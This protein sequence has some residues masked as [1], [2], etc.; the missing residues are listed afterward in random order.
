MNT[1][2]TFIL[3]FCLLTSII[4]SCNFSENAEKRVEQGVKD[5]TNKLIDDAKSAKDNFNTTL[6]T[7]KNSHDYDG[8]TNELNSSSATID[9]IIIDLKLLDESDPNS[10]KD[11]Q[12]IF[13]STQG[14]SLFQQLT[15]TYSQAINSCRD[16]EKRK[17]LQSKADE[18][19]CSGD[20]EKFTKFFFGQSSP[21]MAIWILLGI[22]ADIYN[23]GISCIDAGQ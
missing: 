11:V 3:V 22:K 20:K 18:T 16:N 14:D 2:N 23:N 19:L 15:R 4:C 6:K 9:S 5:N 13:Y 12:H 17:A 1:K 10:Y 21:E 8:L 7:E